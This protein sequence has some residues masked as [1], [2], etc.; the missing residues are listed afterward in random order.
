MLLPVTG[1][2][3][4]NVVIPDCRKLQILETFGTIVDGPMI[5]SRC[6]RGFR[7]CPDRH[8]GPPNLPYNGYRVFPG[9]K[10]AEAWR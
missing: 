1:L 8:W 2:L 4:R 5:E 10:T 6:G 9:G 3:A 7:T